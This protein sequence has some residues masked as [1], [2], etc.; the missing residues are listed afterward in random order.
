MQSKADIKRRHI[1]DTAKQ[2]ILENGFN[3][4]TLEGVAN[5]AGISKGGLLYHFPNKE[6]LIIGIAEYI[7]T[8]FEQNFKKFGENQ[9]DQKGKWT[10]GFIEASKAD[11]T[12]NTELYIGVLAALNAGAEISDNLSEIY[13]S[14]LEKLQ[15]DEIDSVIVNTIRLAIDG[16][17][18]SQV[19]NVSPLEEVK[20]NEVIQQLMKMTRWEG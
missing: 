12:K 8:E 13:N 1:L 17:Y 6:K 10:R 9:P 7:F 18:Y 16:I 2:F 19:L 15:D 5:N 20:V 14:I 11:L 4:L 3:S